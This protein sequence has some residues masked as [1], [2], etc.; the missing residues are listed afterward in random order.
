M[1]KANRWAILSLGACLALSGK[2]NG[3]ISSQRRL[4]FFFDKIEVNGEV[5]VFLKKGKRNRETTVYA[6]SEIIDSVITKVSKRTLYVDANNTYQLARRLPFVKLNARRKFPVEI[7]V[8]IDKLKEIRVHGGSNLTSAE[9]QSD[10]LSVFCSTSGKVH[11]EN[12]LSPT[13]NLRHEGNGVVV[14]KGRGV[15]RLEAQVMGNGSL[16]AEGFD[17]GE[18]TL[19]HQGKEAVH[20]APLRWLDARMR[21]SGNLFLHRQPEKMVIDQAG[22]G[23]VRDVIS[24]PLPFLDHNASAPKLGEEY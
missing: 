12:L 23:I 18:T 11:L 6:D 3:E 19:L 10:G 17:V 20:L 21:G 13:L 7:M 15:N 16:R 5:D 22:K 24:G 4:L 9:L 14:L 8:S 1:A 2:I